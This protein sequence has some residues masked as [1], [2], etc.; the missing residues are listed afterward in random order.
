MI[1]EGLD[2]EGCEGHICSEMLRRRQAF[3]CKQSK[4]THSMSSVV[5]RARKAKELKTEYIHHSAVAQC[6]IAEF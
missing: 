4:Y 1:K 3:F 2:I 5:F 6:V